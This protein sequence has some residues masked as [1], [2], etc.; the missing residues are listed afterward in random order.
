MANHWPRIYVIGV[1]WWHEYRGDS[2]INCP[3]EVWIPVSLLVVVPVVSG[4]WRRWW[5]LVARQAV[6]RCRVLTSN[7]AADWVDASGRLGGTY[8]LPW[9]ADRHA[10]DYLTR[11]HCARNCCGGAGSG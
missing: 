7:D 5:R 10:S 2:P 3:G 1:V 11:W 9:V 4:L 8:R 6:R